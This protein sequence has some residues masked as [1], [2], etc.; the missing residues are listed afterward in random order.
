[1]LRRTTKA[2]AFATGAVLVLLFALA[3]I[4]LTAHA[5]DESLVGKYDGTLRLPRGILVGIS[6]II[7]S[8]DAN[9]KNV[10][11]LVFHHGPFCN[12]P[13]PIEGVMVGQEVS[14]TSHPMPGCGE[15]KFDL[16]RD[17]NE[18]SGTMFNVIGESDI[19]VAKTATSDTG[20]TDT[21]TTNTDAKLDYQCLVGSWEWGFDIGYH[22]L[23]IEKITVAGEKIYLFGSY[24]NYAFG[25]GIDTSKTGRTITGTID[26]RREPH[27]IVF[28]GYGRQDLRW[29]GGGGMWGTA[30]FKGWSGDVEFTK[31]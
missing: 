27:E 8:A 16:R 9:G 4:G 28:T 1:M 14:L 6:I 19:Q 25:S 23:K 10:K 18:L 26:L 3:S 7:T 2:F 5:A 20:A 24:H 30:S 21:A 17:S 12:E 31:K 29:E 22:I 15:R 11:G 13:A